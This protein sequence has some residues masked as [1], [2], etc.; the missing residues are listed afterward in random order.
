MIS[1]G[2][3]LA[4]DILGCCHE[5]EAQDQEHHRR[6]G[7]AAVPEKKDDRHG[8]EAEEPLSGHHLHGL[9]GQEDPQGRLDAPDDRIG[10]PPFDPTDGVRGGEPDPD[11]PHGEG[12]GVDEGRAPVLGDGHD[13]EDL[14]GLDGHGEAVGDP[15]DDVGQAHHDQEP[16]GVQAAGDDIAD[17]QGEG[18]CRNPP[19]S[20]RIPAG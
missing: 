3:G 9:H 2:L 10:G 20:P 1:W 18:G 7:I 5:G 6:R 19:E 12:G 8:Q 17:G 11:K 4:S 16:C 13:G 14:H 15:G